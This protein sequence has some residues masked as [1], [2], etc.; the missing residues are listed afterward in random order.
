MKNYEHVY[1]KLTIIQLKS[2]EVPHHK[3]RTTYIGREQE[4]EMCA[5]DNPYLLQYLSWHIRYYKGFWQME[6]KI[7]LIG[8]RGLIGGNVDI[9]RQINKSNFE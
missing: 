7:P 3:I 1:T 9:C 8:G 2:V 6:K 5:C 4:K